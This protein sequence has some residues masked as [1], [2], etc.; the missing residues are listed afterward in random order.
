MRDNLIIF[1]KY[2]EPGKVKTRIAKAVGNEKAAD[3]YF[4]LAS[5]VV[6]K[7]TGSDDFKVSVAFTPQSRESL[8]KS[9]LNKDKF[10]YFPQNGRTLGERISSAFD[11]SF[12][13]GFQNAVV[14]GS[15]CAELDQKTIKA[16]F[17]HLSN[18]SDCVI[19][20]THDGGYYLIGLRHKNFPYIFEDISWSSDSVFDETVTKLTSLNL[21][22]TVLRKLGDID[23]AGDID[24]NLMKLLKG[25]SV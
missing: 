11:R 18:G 1:V 21:K 17:A 12:A 9:W 4:S 6:N 16:A 15:D 3:L 25:S 23:N 24:D 2:P 5:H 13:N 10:D 19:G 14:I 7:T 20:P 22:W 8:I